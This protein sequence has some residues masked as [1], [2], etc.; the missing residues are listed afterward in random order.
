MKTGL[1]EREYNRALETAYPGVAQR[2]MKRRFMNWPKEP[3]TK[4]SYYFPRLGEMTCWGP[5]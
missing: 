2:I 1:R 5:F 3:W 4:A